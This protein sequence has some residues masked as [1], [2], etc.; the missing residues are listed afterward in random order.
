MPEGSSVYMTSFY[1]WQ[2]FQQKQVQYKLGHEVKSSYDSKRNRTD[3]KETERRILSSTKYLLGVWVWPLLLISIW[4]YMEWNRTE[5]SNI[6]P[7]VGGFKG[8]RWKG[9]EIN[10]FFVKD[11]LCLQRRMPVSSHFVSDNHFN[12][13]RICTNW[14]IA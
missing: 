6:W 8:G 2:S 5:G 1:L 13:N 4:L 3:Q 12:K 11:P 9:V 14:V 10:K 7:T